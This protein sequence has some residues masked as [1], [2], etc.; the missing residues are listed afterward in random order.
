MCVLL[1]GKELVPASSH[2]YGTQTHTHTH[3][4]THPHMQSHQ[5]PITLNVVMSK[6]EFAL[7]QELS[8]CF[9]TL[10]LNLVADSN[11]VTD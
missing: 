10:Q 2:T 5:A 8:F 4:H 3:T 11:L 7:V 6:L 9:H 1:S